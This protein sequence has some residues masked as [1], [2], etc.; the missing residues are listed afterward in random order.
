MCSG[1]DCCSD[2][3]DRAVGSRLAER[4]RARLR[5]YSVARVLSAHATFRRTDDGGFD[6]LSTFRK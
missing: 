1:I 5:N 4:F 6:L 2:D 3:Q